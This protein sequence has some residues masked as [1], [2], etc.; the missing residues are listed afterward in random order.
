MRR[1]DNAVAGM[2]LMGSSVLVSIVASLVMSFPWQAILLVVAATVASVALIM[3]MTSAD[4]RRDTESWQEAV[5]AVSAW[6]SRNAGRCETTRDAFADDDLM[7]PRS[8][9]FSG[10]IL[11]AGHRH[12]FEVGV[13]CSEESDVD[14]ELGRRTAFFVRLSRECPHVR[15]EPGQLRR[16]PVADVPQ[17]VAALLAALPARAELVETQDQELR[18]VYVGWPESIDLDVCVDASVE[19]ARALRREDIGEPQDR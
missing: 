13:A 5:V 18:I 12:G 19:V 6:A 17:P 2:V 14:G 7:L 3:A 4:E 16:R 1:T 11:A 9:R 10:S 8:P 15:V